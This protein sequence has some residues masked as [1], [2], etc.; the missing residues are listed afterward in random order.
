MME[1]ET[2]AALESR[3]TRLGVVLEPSG[4][5]HEVE[6]VLNP[7]A[8]RTREGQLAAH[9]R[10]VAEGN[11]SRVALVEADE[12]R[13]V[14]RRLGYALEPQVAYEFRPPG[15]GYG[16]EDPRVTFVP[17]LDAYVMAYTA[18]G[19]PG[20]RI[21]LALSR[22]GHVWERLGVVDFSA[23]GFIDQDDKDGMFFPEPVVSPGGEPSLALYHRPMHRLSMMT[24]YYPFPAAV[25]G[26]KPEERESIRIAYVSLDA[27]RAERRALLE[28][29]ESVLVVAPTG[30]WGQLKTGGGTPP[31]AI[32]EGWLSLYHAVDMVETAPGEKLTR[33]YSA[34]IL[35]HDRERPHIVRYRSP[36]PIMAPQHVDEL[37]GT[38]NNVVFPTGLDHVPGDPPRTFEIYY[39]MADSRV[40]RARLEVGAST[41]ALVPPAASE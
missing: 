2:I 21:A 11:V 1:R 20:P 27:V 26:M 12:G 40:G 9:P 6:G 25:L 7:A 30:D 32:D 13:R 4:D 3:V 5:P 24:D 38:V 34:G 35:I 22:D 8:T 41:Q 23:A 17:V 28:V 31:V 39:G 36:Q 19:P 18:F 16:C 33:R 14:F 37:R 10:V 15:R 29:R